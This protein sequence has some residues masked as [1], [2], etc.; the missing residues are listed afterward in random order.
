MDREQ[1][2]RNIINNSI[3]RIVGT[4]IHP[5]DIQQIFFDL[6]EYVDEQIAALAGKIERVELVFDSA[7]RKIYL[8]R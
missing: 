6:L 4:R 8:K 5:Q 1:L 3:G 7:T 2:T